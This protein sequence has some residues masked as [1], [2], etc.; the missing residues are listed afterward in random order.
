MAS[1]HVSKLKSRVQLELKEALMVFR[2][3]TSNLANRQLEFTHYPPSRSMTHRQRR[4]PLWD[5]VIN[6]SFMK[7]AS[8]LG[9]VR[10]PSERYKFVVNV[11]QT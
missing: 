2:R 6:L 9:L 10:T 7:F 4:L 5:G 3:M 8:Y 11:M 1:F